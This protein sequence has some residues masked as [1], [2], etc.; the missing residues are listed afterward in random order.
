VPTA[1]GA[2]QIQ[3]K[4]I[5]PIARLDATF[6]RLAYCEPGKRKTDF[7]DEVVQGF[8]LEVRPSGGKTYYLRFT[9]PNGRRQ[10]AVKIARYGDV[11]FNQAK[12]RAEKLRGE[13]A[14][15][16]DP[17]LKKEQLRAVPTYADFAKLHLE[18][19]E[20][21]QR[22]S[23]NTERIL[24]IHVVPRWGKLRLDEIHQPDV[25]K[26][27]AA[28]REEGLAA[29]T[30]EKIRVTFGRSFELAMRWNTPGVSRNPT[31][32]IPRK[33]LNNARERFLSSEEAERLL[34]AAYASSNTQLG[35][36]AELLLLTGARV[37]EL[38]HAEWRHVDR[39]RAVWFIP[40]SKTGKSRHVPLSQPALAVIDRLPRFAG[41]PFLV[42]NPKT[43]KPFTNIKRPWQTV[44]DKAGLPGLR[45]HDLRH[46]AASF[47]INSGF[48]LYEVGKVLGHTNHASTLRYSHLTDDTLRA[49]V[50]AG[51]AKMTMEWA[52]P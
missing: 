18:F 20:T 19:A 52:H 9:A 51:A 22:R 33:P 26:W 35:Y 7:W 15:G 41:C 29:A 4:I 2:I 32:G 50:E 5:M 40:I 47:M 39:Q 37:S 42:P 30:V 43:R 46:S 17:A 31:R 38:L 1:A 28:K 10:R 21:H 14:F 16:T 49:A 11:T 45:V 25:A 44:R 6:C 23:C 3:R 48:G 13:V 8:V 24:R 12:R 27:L 36:I 34:K